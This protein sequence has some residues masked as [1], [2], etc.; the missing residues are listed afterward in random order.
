MRV[1]GQDLMKVDSMS[2]VAVRIDPRGARW[3]AGR[4]QRRKLGQVRV[5]PRRLRC[6]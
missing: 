5:D 4:P 6:G 3:E 2:L 1:V